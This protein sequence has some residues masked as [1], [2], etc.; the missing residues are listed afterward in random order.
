MQS[1]E[2]TPGPDPASGP[3]S[4]LGTKPPVPGEVSTVARGAG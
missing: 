1:S 2:C 3:L 4:A